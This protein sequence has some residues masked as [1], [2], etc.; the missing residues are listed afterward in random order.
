M[1]AGTGEA[2]NAESRWAEAAR[3]LIDRLQHLRGQM[4]RLEALYGDELAQ[5][6][7][8]QRPSARN[9]LHYVALRR[10]DIRPLQEELVGWGLSSLGRCETHVLSNLNLVLEILMRLS[11]QSDASS[12]LPEAELNF[13]RGRE[14]LDSR[15]RDLF[16][17][18]PEDRGAHIMVT[19]PAT[20]AE[21]YD[22]VRDLL[23]SGMN[24]MRINCA[25]DDA[26]AWAAMIDN[27][28]RAERELN[29]PCRVMM[30]LAGPKLR[31][32]P[33]E[34]GPSVVKWQPQRDLYGRVIQ[35]ARI[36]IYPADLPSPPPGPASA[37]V[38]LEGAWLERAEVGDHWRLRDARGRLRLLRVVD[39]TPRGVWVETRRTAFV[40][41]R[42]PLLPVEGKAAE[43]GAEEPIGRIGLLPARQQA[44]QLKPGDQLVVTDDRQ[45]GRPARYD[46]RGQLLQPASIGCTLAS[47][48]ADVRPGERMLFDDGK[49]AA[50]IEQVH[51]D[52][53]VVRIKRARQQ[54]AWLAA[55]KG[56]NLPD[57]KLRLAALTDKDAQDLEFIARHADLVA[58]S[59]VRRAEDVQHLQAELARLGNAGQGIVLKIENRQAC[60]RL[61]G[62]L[63][64]AM[65]SPVAGVMIARGDLMIECG[66]QRMAE[67]QEEILWMCEAAHMP[68][69]WATQVLEGLAKRGLPSRAE[70]TDAAM[71][72]R[73]ECVMLNKGP[74]IVDAVRVLDDILKRMQDHQVKKRPLL[75][76][77][78]LADDLQ[79]LPE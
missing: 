72:V 50:E 67:L 55:D 51:A 64:A 29:R 19:M 40:T 48:F 39:W 26:T 59:F 53:L 36:W 3:R 77:L 73:A 56:I 37:A 16:G 21:D 69:I 22:L 57:S 78:R 62:I 52:H 74:H 13:Q 76:R 45:P 20:A 12:T 79:P 1:R 2:G 18:L 30:D 24:C 47:I 54:G 42:S 35:P 11:G 8:T 60:E 33:I 9:L 6:A 27:L 28:R 41:S 65:R 7:E 46:D 38:P 25:H 4:L 23:A 68:V 17:H 15:A 34:P 66:W 61:P 70:V 71:G 49:I 31:T 5:L 75:R 58:Y 63:L 10:N 32:G 14:L 43:S 44:I